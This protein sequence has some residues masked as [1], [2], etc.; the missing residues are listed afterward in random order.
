MVLI[1]H[2]PV[3]ADLIRPG[4]LLVILVIQR[5]RLHGIEISVRKVEA[6]RGVLGQVRLLHR[7]VGLLGVKEDFHLLL[8]QD[9][10]SAC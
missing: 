2:D 9:L 6:T 8:H 3:E 7:R 10:L 5:M 1:G 4:I